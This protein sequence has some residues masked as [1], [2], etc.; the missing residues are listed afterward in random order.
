MVLGPTNYLP[1]SMIQVTYYLQ[2]MAQ[3]PKNYLPSFMIQDLPSVV[4]SHSEIS[5]VKKPN[6]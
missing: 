3:G 5:T 1:S 2:I 6:V 4:Y